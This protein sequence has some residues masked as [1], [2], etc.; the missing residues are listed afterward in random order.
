MHDDSELVEQLWINPTAALTLAANLKLM[1]PAETLGGDQHA[2]PMSTRCFRTGAQALTRT[3]GTVQ[4]QIGSG[5]GH[6]PVT[7]DSRPA[8]DDRPPVAAADFSYEIHPARAGAPVAARDPRLRA[9]T[10]A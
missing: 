10:A 8:G 6:A 2:S 5:H 1:T 3:G 9:H 7:P 4:P